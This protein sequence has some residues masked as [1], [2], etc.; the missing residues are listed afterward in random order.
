MTSSIRGSQI[1]CLRVC[2]GFKTDPRLFEKWPTT[3]HC[4]LALLVTL[5]CM[6]P[7]VPPGPVEDVS[8]RH[9]DS[10][11][12][13]IVADCGDVQGSVDQQGIRWWSAR[14]KQRT[15][16]SWVYDC[17]LFQKLRRQ[18]KNESLSCTFR[19]GQRT[20]TQISSAIPQLCTDPSMLQL[21]C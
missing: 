21:D 17:R 4:S 6:K 3:F 9:E 8:E 5:P 19:N 2:Q 13:L 15:Q 10:G 11:V 20:L 1:T 16:P 14:K 18:Y 7:K 12:P